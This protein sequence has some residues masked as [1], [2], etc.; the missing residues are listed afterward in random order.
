MK[1]AFPGIPW[2]WASGQPASDPSPPPPKKI[3]QLEKLCV[4]GSFYI[5]T[6]P[7]LQMMD[8]GGKADLLLSL[9]PAAMSTVLVPGSRSS[10]SSSPQGEV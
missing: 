4:L 6:K 5:Q 8:L 9:D 1:S 3:C 7:N 10:R 2:A